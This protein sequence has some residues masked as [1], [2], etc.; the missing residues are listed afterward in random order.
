MEYDGEVEGIHF[1]PLQLYRFALILTESGFKPLSNDQLQS[2]S[3][4]Q[5]LL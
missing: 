1:C 4:P 5:L 2:L 3:I